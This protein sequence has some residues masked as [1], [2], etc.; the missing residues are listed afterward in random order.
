MDAGNGY[1]QPSQ[2][3]GRFMDSWYFSVSPALVAVALIAAGFY[4]A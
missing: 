3:E 2:F 1:L 4:F